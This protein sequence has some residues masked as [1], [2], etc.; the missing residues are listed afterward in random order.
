MIDLIIKKLVSL[1]C[2]NFNFSFI[3]SECDVIIKAQSN[4]VIKVRDIE[5]IIHPS[6]IVEFSSKSDYI[7]LKFCESLFQ[8]L[9]R[10]TYLIKNIV[11]EIKEEIDPPNVCNNDEVLRF[12]RELNNIARNWVQDLYVRVDKKY[13]HLEGQVGCDNPDCWYDRNMDRISELKAIYY[14]PIEDGYT[15]CDVCG[16]DES[17]NEVAEEIIQACLESW[18]IEL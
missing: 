5:N 3:S 1:G 18:N 11:Q 12:E 6:Q 4:Q 9:S 7:E 16:Y 13:I 17:E 10:N 8:S 2:E 15:Y 14:L